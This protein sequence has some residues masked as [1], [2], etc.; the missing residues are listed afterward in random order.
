VENFFRVGV[1]VIKGILEDW[2]SKF[3]QGLEPGNYIGDI[4]GSLGGSPDF[5]PGNIQGDGG[6]FVKPS[7]E[8][9]DLGHSLR[10]E[11]APR[12]ALVRRGRL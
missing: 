6:K 1:A 11:L 3:D 12:R 8:S 10:P 2:D 9:G 4:F 5:G 7:G